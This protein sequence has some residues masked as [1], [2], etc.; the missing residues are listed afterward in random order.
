MRGEMTK[1]TLGKASVERFY[2]GVVA[3][4]VVKGLSYV[5]LEDAYQMGILNG[6]EPTRLLVAPKTHALV[7]EKLMAPGE[8]LNAARIEKTVTVPEGVGLFLGGARVV[9]LIVEDIERAERA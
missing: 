3:V 2:C 7:V 9:T 6:A 5:A 1:T 8:Y 4:R